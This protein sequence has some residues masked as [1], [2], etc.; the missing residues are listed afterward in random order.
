MA[1]TSEQQ[2][3][4]SSAGFTFSWTCHTGELLT[5]I[6]QEISNFPG[7]QLLNGQL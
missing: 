1:I 5:Q 6:K 4:C 3:T 2:T 7:E